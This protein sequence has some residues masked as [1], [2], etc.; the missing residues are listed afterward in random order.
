MATDDSTIS[1]NIRSLLVKPD[2]SPNADIRFAKVPKVSIDELRAR[3]AAA[4]YCPDTVLFAVR[5]EDPLSEGSGFQSVFEVFRYIHRLFADSTKR[6]F[7]ACSNA[8]EAIRSERIKSCQDETI[9]VGG[10]TYVERAAQ[11]VRDAMQRYSDEQ[12]CP[13]GW[14]KARLA[15]VALT[16]FATIEYRQQVGLAMLE[17]YRQ[18]YLGGRCEEK[19]GVWTGFVGY[20]CADVVEPPPPQ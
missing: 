14:Y 17:E 13:R 15:D 12:L 8:A 11:C 1:V 19:R 7:V 6:E 10:R 16:R 18:A 3:P 9:D 5:N 4:R 2:W 20:T